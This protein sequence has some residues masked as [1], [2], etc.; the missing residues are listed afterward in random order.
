MYRS[1]QQWFGFSDENLS[2][3]ERLVG[4]DQTTFFPYVDV[5]PLKSRLRLTSLNCG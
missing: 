5:L 1:A 4:K 2:V 3:H